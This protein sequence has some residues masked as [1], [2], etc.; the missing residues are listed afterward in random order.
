MRSPEASGPGPGTSSHCPSR[1]SNAA[2][3]PSSDPF[4]RYP[5]RRRP[6]TGTEQHDLVDVLPGDLRCGGLVPHQRMATEN[7]TLIIDVQRDPTRAHDQGEDQRCGAARHDDRNP[8]RHLWISQ[9]RSP[10]PRAKPA[11]GQ[12]FPRQSVACP[13]PHVVCPHPSWPARDAR[14]AS[15]RIVRDSFGDNATRPKQHPARI[16]AHSRYG[17]LCWR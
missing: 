1:S 13:V 15:R 11:T 8:L 2:T 16:P 10:Q 4:G 9:S 17:R 6:A 5:V 7:H 12:H 14:T 3:P